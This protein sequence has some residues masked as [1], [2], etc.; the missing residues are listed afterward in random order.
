MRLVR[1]AR[2]FPIEVQKETKNVLGFS[3]IEDIQ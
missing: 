1:S 2:T 3:N